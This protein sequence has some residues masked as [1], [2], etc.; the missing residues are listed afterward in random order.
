M[1]EV[2]QALVKAALQL[3]ARS[4]HL[5]DIK[6]SAVSHANAAGRFS[7]VNRI[8]LIPK[9]C[10]IDFEIIN[11]FS[12]PPNSELFWMV[13]KQGRKAENVNDLG[14]IAGVG[15][16][17]HERSAS[18]NLAALTQGMLLRLWVVE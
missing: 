4:V 18:R 16:T 15:L 14:H 5:P 17:A 13:R 10:D 9:D 1:P 12:L 6:V 8:S 3:P 7:G 11:P 2:T